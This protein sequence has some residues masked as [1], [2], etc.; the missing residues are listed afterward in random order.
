[1]WTSTSAVAGASP[2]QCQSVYA[3]RL[4]SVELLPARRQAAVGRLDSTARAVRQRRGP[5]LDGSGHRPPAQRQQPR[6]PGC[7]GRSEPT[8]VALLAD[9]VAVYDAGRREPLP[10]PLKTSFAWCQAR[11]TGDD[12]MS[13]PRTSVAPRELRRRELRPRPRPRLGPNTPLKVLL[14][15]TRPGEERPG[16]PTRL[17][18]YA[19]RVWEPMLRFEQGAP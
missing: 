13:R 7:S 8:P 16:E 17:G 11:R 2:A 15:P 6:E 18:A 1:M 9:L 19:A 3:Y 5:Q 4:V 14:E 10:L 12:P